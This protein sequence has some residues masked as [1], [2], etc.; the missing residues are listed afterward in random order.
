MPKLIRCHCGGSPECK[1]C[2]GTG[3]YE[4]TPGDLG[5]MPFNCPTCEGNGVMKDDAGVESPC[6][7]CH[8]IGNVDPANP[9][10]A[11]MWDVLTKILFGA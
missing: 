5:Y 9:P 1:L 7:T 11:G 6:K 3:K 2:K 4:Y 10:V 8:G